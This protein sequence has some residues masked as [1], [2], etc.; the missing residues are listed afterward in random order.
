MNALEVPKDLVRTFRDDR[1]GELIAL[2]GLDKTGL[3][4]V[5][6]GGRAASIASRFSPSR[7]YLHRKKM[8]IR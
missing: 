7:L 8:M 6:V 4:R 3:K 2:V 5:T 1:G